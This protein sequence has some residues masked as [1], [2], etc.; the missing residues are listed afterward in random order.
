MRRGLTGLG[1][2]MMLRRVVS[3][4]EVI[5]FISRQNM[6][7]AV[8]EEKGWEGDGEKKRDCGCVCVCVWLHTIRT[9]MLNSVRLESVTT[10]SRGLHEQCGRKLQRLTVSHVSQPGQE[11][12]ELLLTFCELAAPAVVHPEASHDAVDDQQ[13]VVSGGEVGR[14]LVEQVHLVLVVNV[15]LPTFVCETAMERW[16][17]T[18]LAVH[19]SCVG[20]VVLRLLRVHAESLCDLYDALRTKRAFGVDVGHFALGAAE[21]LRQLCD[22]GHRVGHLRLS[23]SLDERVSGCRFARRTMATGS[24]ILN[25]PK[26]LEGDGISTIVCC[27][28]KDIHGLRLTSLILML[29]KPLE[30]I[31][32]VRRPRST[33]EEGTIP[34][35]YSIK[36]LAPSRDL[37]YLP[38]LLPEL[39]CRDEA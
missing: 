18:Y 19:R 13:T 22:D 23:A 24:H 26:I 31:I 30:R 32:S 38:A 8:G 37:V 1:L 14:E 39:L 5:F 36:L 34:S 20:D 9:Q 28:C 27:T 11:L 10:C 33:S 7:A 21:F 4:V 35:K 6:E 2:S 29:W 16:R 12:V 15:R 25:S 17:S 3:E